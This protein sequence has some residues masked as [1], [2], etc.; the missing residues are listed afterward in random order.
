MATNWKAQASHARHDWPHVIHAIAHEDG[1]DAELEN[2]Q[3]VVIDA[4]HVQ[5]HAT[6]YL[7][8][9][10]TPDTRTAIE[11]NMFAAAEDA[12]E[13]GRILAASMPPVVIKTWHVVVNELGALPGA[14]AFYS[15]DYQALVNVR[16]PLHADTWRVVVGAYGTERPD[17][18]DLPYYVAIH[19]PDVEWGTHDL[20]YLF[21][22]DHASQPAAIEFA[23]LMIGAITRGD[24]VE[25]LAY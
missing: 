6:R 11:S 7:C 2:L 14:R 5:Y 8:T 19:R 10:W 15:D 18:G 20:M 13:Y 17:S 16:H 23:R 4:V 24:A 12:L 1:M 3:R 22:R 9:L 21:H 25:Y